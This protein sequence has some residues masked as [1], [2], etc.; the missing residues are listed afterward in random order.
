M[1]AC[2]LSADFC[3]LILIVTGSLLGR[4]VPGSSVWAY[5]PIFAAEALLCCA[6]S[7]CF[8]M[9]HQPGTPRGRDG[10][11]PM[12][13]VSCG[14]T[15]LC[16]FC[17]I[18]VFNYLSFVPFLKNISPESLTLS[19]ASLQGD[20]SFADGGILIGDNG[21]S[22]SF[23][24]IGWTTC[25]FRIQAAKN[26]KICTVEVKIRDD[27]MAAD[28]YRCGS[29]DFC[30]DSP[31]TTVLPVYSAGKLESV[32]FNFSSDCAG[33][34]IQGITVDQPGFFFSWGRFLL[35]SL[36]GC[37]FFWFVRKKAWR[38]S[39]D[40]SSGLH[41]SLI[42]LLAVLLC[43]VSLALGKAASGEETSIPYP[44]QKAPGSYGCYVEQFDA[45]QKGQLNLD[46]Q[47]DPKLKA[48]SNPYDHS[49][50][51]AQDVSFSWDRSYYNGKYYSYFGVAPIFFVYY[52]YYFLFHALPTDARAAMI[53]ALWAI[54]FLLLLLRELALRTCKKINLPL[55]L[56]G[57]TAAVFSTMLFMLQISADFYYIAYLSELL[58]VCA[59]LFLVLRAD[60]AR[61]PG[62]RA[63]LLFFSGISYVLAVGSRPVAVFSIVLAAPVLFRSLLRGE[64]RLPHRL[65]RLC[66]FGAPV[67]CGALALMEYNSLRFG[68]P[69]EFGTTY[70]LTI[71]NMSYNRVGILNIIPAVYHYFFQLPSLD[72]KFPFLH[73]IDRQFNYYASYKL[74]IVM[75][76]MMSFPSLWWIFGMRGAPAYRERRDVRTLFWTAVLL[77]LGIAVLNYSVS[78]MDIRYVTDFS[79]YLSALS[80]LIILDR[81]QIFTAG[82]L[83]ENM[84][85]YRAFPYA[86][87]CASLVLT[88]LMGI[89]VIFSNER[90]T[91][92]YS[93]PAF[94]A[95]LERLCMFW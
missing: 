79:L 71:D 7:L 36:L 27:N 80:F 6:S 87:S 52:P 70:Q 85:A 29:Y 5:F 26:Q 55:F 61:G 62:A 24:R 74:H 9:L 28:E 57:M 81:D 38:I 60:R 69:F 17:E 20:A 8:W 10:F 68:S 92:Y 77:S 33:L 2:A 40:R 93:A 65:A 46:L 54:P 44:L 88:V 21:G 75:L 35:L 22:V 48:M 66:A 94:Y 18:F 86:L 34:L 51:I 23:N 83:S 16:L 59:F 63:L 13:A 42:A 1:L 95:N 15:A 32:R 78:G 84:A 43:F 67:L 53:L 41:N 64:G 25:C 14:I 47:V 37:G 4:A 58:F 72:P 12:L 56:L 89:A 49:A 30:I 19:T 3:F 91:I 82:R 73:V 31:R 45:F 39:Y 90:N 76:G 50:R 11:Y